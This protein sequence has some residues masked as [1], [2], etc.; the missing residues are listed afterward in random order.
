MDMSI[1]ANSTYAS[2]VS[3]T[4]ATDLEKNLANRNTDKITDVEAMEACKEFEAY[5]LEQVY[6]SMEKTVMRAEDKSD[7][8]EYFGDMM[9]Q[10][11][12]KRAV[13]QGGI[14]LANQL[15]E[16]MKNNNQL[17]VTDNN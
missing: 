7:Y 2:I 1:G 16:A 8:E 11:Y 13:D 12:A 5:M 17:N 3:Q 14:G 10:E 4:Q 6:K 9:I 15:Y